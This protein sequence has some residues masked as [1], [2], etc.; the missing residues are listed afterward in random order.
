MKPQVNVCLTVVVGIF[1]FAQAAPGQ[2]IAANQPGTRS[3][4]GG[5]STGAIAV[6][7]A[8][9]GAPY[10][11][12]CDG[13]AVASELGSGGG[14]VHPVSLAS[15]DLDED[16]VPDLVS[17]YATGG[18]GT[19][20]V[21]RGNEAALW[22]YGA[23][24]RNGPLPAFL[25]Q[26]RSFSLPESPDFLVTGDFDADGHTDV[27][28]AHRGGGALYFLKGDGRG[29]FLKPKRV[30]VD[31]SITAMISG[32][33]N[34]PDG[35]ADIV[36][37][38]NT[39]NGTRVLVFES[40]RGAVQ[41]QP[42]IFRVNHPVT[43]L[44][45][46][47]F[48]G[49]AMNDLAV[50]AGDELM[51]IHARDRKLSMGAAERASVPRARITMQTEPF[52]IQAL[53]AGDFSGAGPSIAA[54]GN[55]G[56]IHI[57]EHALA[58]NNLLA[59]MLA[60]PAYTPAMQVPG[61]SRK[62]LPVTGAGHIAPSLAA[63]LE[64]LRHTLGAEGPE[65][66]EKN[67]VPLPS[68]FAQDAPRLVAARVSGSL[69]EDLVAPDSGNN[70]LHIFS[71]I[72]K[73]HRPGAIQSV[74]KMSLLASLD[75]EASPAA[76][77]PMRLS[78]SGLHGLVILQDGTT[79]PIVMQQTI[80]PGNI[81]T[82]TNTSD[83]II[84]AGTE[85]TGPAGSLRAAIYNA[86]NATGPAEVDFDIPTSD[87]GYNSATGTFL[88][89]PLSEAAPG[90][91]NDFALP[92]I[93]QTITI[94]GYTQPG[95]SP[96]TSSTT[97]N[98]KILIEI[99]GTMATTPGG[100]GLVPFDDTGSTY[101]GLDFTGWTNPD[102]ESGP[103]GETASG[104][105]GMEANGV[106]DYI[107][108]NFFGT[109]P[110]GTLAISAKTSSNYGNRIGIFA[111]NG[112]GFGNMEGGNII[113]GT[114]PQARNILSNNT[115]GGVLFLSTA[116]E[117]HLEGNFIGLDASGAKALGNIDDGAGS[118][119]ATITLGGTLPGDGNV[120]SSN[121]TDIDFND[122]TN[123]GQASDSIAQGNLIGTDAT[124]T[125]SV[126]LGNGVG[127][128]ILSGPTDETFGGTT[129]AARNVISGNLYGVYIFNY[130][131]GNIVQGNFIGTDVTGTKAIGNALQGF[132][133]GATD[134]TQVPA[135]YTA[136]GGSVA[137]AGNVIS[138]NTLDGVSISGTA[139]GGPY[140]TNQGSTILG[141]YIGTDV[142]G[143]KALGNGATGISL[144]TAA[145]SNVIGGTEPGSGNIIAFNKSHGILIDSASSGA[146]NGNNT[147]GNTILSNGG[148]G[149]RINSGADN[150]ISQN[151]IYQNAALGIDL[152]TAGPNA[153]TS[154]NS[155]NTG[156]NNSQ[157]APVLTAGTGTA[158]FTATATDP[159]GN[160]S[161]F[162]N[163]VAST[164]GNVFDLL[165][166]FNSTPST[167]YTIEF[168]SSPTGDPSGFGQ[169]LTYLGSTQ[170]TTGA[171]CSIAVNTPL[172]PDDADMSITLSNPVAGL[173][174]GPDFGEQVY[175]ASV[176]NLGASTA[177]NVVV[178]DVLPPSLEISSL[179]CN[180]GPCQFSVTTSLG[181]CTVNGQ[182]ITCDLG[183]MAPGQTAVVN[184]PVEAV[185][186]ETISNT[187][188]VSA[189]EADPVLA[190]NSSTVTTRSTYP[191]PEI[192]IE[193]A[194][195]NFVPNSAIAGSPNLPVTVYGTGFIPSSVVSFNGTNL[196][197][198]SFV[199]NQICGN[200]F[201][202]Y[203][204]AA[205]EVVV[206]A[207]MLT[208]VGTPNITVTNP[209]PGPGGAANVASVG[210]FNIYSACS[211]TI[212][213]SPDFADG[214]ENDGTTLI[215]E[216]VSVAANAASCSWTASS[217]V[218]WVVPL[219]TTPM[220]GEYSSLDFAVAPNSSAATRSGTITV[221]GQTVSFTQAASSSCD[222]TLGA[223]SGNFTPAGGAGSV[224]VTIIGSG[225]AP[226]V[227]SYASWITVPEASG[228]LLASGPATFT[229]AANTG[230]ART[231]TIMIG[232]YVFTVNQSAPSC[233]Y[234][235]SPATALWGAAGGTGA[236]G[237]TASSSSCAWTA[238]SSN[239]SVAT[240]TSGGS[241]TGN[242]TVNYSVAANKNGPQTPT[243]TV[244]DTN[245][246]SSAF[247]ISQASAYV[248]TFTIS[249]T[250]VSVP[251]DGTSNFF[252]LTASNNFC[253]WTATS[254]DPSALSI[255]L[256]SSGTGNGAVYY[257]VAQNTSG[258]R[259]ITIVAGCQ[260]FTVNQDGTA[261]SNPLPAITT[262]QPSGATAG[263]GAFTLTVNGS[264]FINGSV[265][266][267]NGNPRTTTYVSANQ[268]TAAILATDVATAGKP[269]VTVINP[270]PGGGT[271]NVVDFNITAALITPT[272]TVSP[273]PASITT[274]QSLTVTI[275]VAGGSG[276]PTPTGSVTLTSGSYTSAATT[277]SSG[278]T[279]INIPAGSLATGTDTLT[280]SYTPDSSSSSTYNSAT[281]SNTV[282]VTTPAKVTPTVAVSP[283]PSSI[284]T[285]QGLTVTVTVGGGSG[286]PTPTGSVTLSGGGYTS[287]VTTLTG[288][289]A[290]FTIA[291]GALAT[292][293]DTLTAS[294]TPDSSSSSTYNS[295]TGSNTVAVTTAAK[296]T[297]S[298]T[299]SPSPASITTKQPLTVTITVAGGTGNP[300]PTGSVVLTSGTYTSATTALSGGAATITIAAGTL[301]KGTD[302]LNV[303]Y[304]PDTA[305]STTY[306]SATGSNTVMVTT[307]GP[308]TPTVTV[309][310]S[311]A[312]ITT[313]QALTVNVAVSGGTGNPTPTGSVVL[314]SGTYTSAATTLSGGAAAI[315]ISA[316]TLPV[317]TDTLTVAYTPDTTSSTT[318]NPATGSNTVVVAAVVQVTVGTNPTS[319][320]FT[321][322]GTTYTSS[323]SLTWTVGTSHTIATTSPQTSGSTQYAFT[324]WSDGGALS[325]TVTAPATATT[326][327]AAFSTS[328]QLTTAA[329][330]SA[331]GTVTP[332]SG[333]FYAA[334]TV[335]NLS[336]TANTGFL[337]SSWTGNVASAS[338]ATT[339]VTMNAAQS[340][341]ANFA[342]APAP[343]ALLAP[344]S[345][346]FSAVAG[347]TSAAQMATISNTGN[348]ALTNI[349]ISITG[350]NASNFAQSAT[351]CGTTLAAGDACTISITFAPGAAGS[352]SAT[353]SVTDNAAGSPQT[354][355]LSGTGTPAPSFTVTS[356]TGSQTVQ[357]G[358]VAQYSITIAA[359]N[360]T[361]SNPVA[362]SAS[363][364][365]PGATAT[366]SQATVTPGSSS[367][368]SQLSIQTAGATAAAAGFMSSRW[369]LAGA[370]PLFGLLAVGRQ[371]R[372]RWM[373]FAVLLFASLGAVTAI[374]GCGGGFG[375]RSA[376]SY[377]ITVTGTSGAEQQTA[378]VQL[379]VQ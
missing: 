340:V 68:G 92:P 156:A 48:D 372:R 123:G 275:T 299:V 242:G 216:N 208:A 105:E 149:V 301:P 277:L 10:L 177:H 237:V 3:C 342:P 245:G 192:D 217:S 120:I 306:N 26:A 113:G 23:A 32:E 367:A 220:S 140:D 226:F 79:A 230:A 93:N 370:I 164:S 289:T 291:A 325:H 77:L 355:T 179:Y 231:G 205:I 170:V 174:I 333:T 157:N 33:I 300:T 151:S 187:A 318:Y 127:A 189:T 261:V 269:P 49:G 138:G 144:L 368:T 2:R 53:V 89:Q 90:A 246:G 339:T 305:S 349:A 14:A 309:T 111:D 346:S 359:Q 84:T 222:Y 51:V 178:T 132:Y 225:C 258:P 70:A 154:C 142:T 166:N 74:A 362:L 167:A 159:N 182:T 25:P 263:S 376:T 158:F 295:A 150:L 250:P 203:Y 37:G 215:A 130:T 328:Y 181:S 202:P 284:T 379:T 212:T 227:E 165:G 221:A 6:H 116:L 8:L 112:P 234:T 218:D 100:A 109:D 214:L 155:T 310:P 338:S 315:N 365:P 200:S 194:L 60:D 377:T 44:A 283:S 239:T 236:F 238:T 76:V 64:T 169:G 316:G 378:T 256:N 57:L 104:A 72:S 87:P 290:T 184:I 110:T 374:T 175:T 307:P 97:D 240:V 145:S 329:S 176:V 5:S 247:A 253:Q 330:P 66:M 327:T 228:L 36:I 292:G 125:L 251:A 19:I 323:Q 12:L 322:D 18:G 278:S 172:N 173:Q 190:N 94:D 297:P 286:N 62:G 136:L 83:A 115:A 50:G 279:T 183:T 96:N 99:D 298:V 241:G 38:V 40:P 188:T 63:R 257:S 108:G 17:G 204:C 133:Q 80:P 98:A 1:A 65:W 135:I 85:V 354:T 9:R 103:S 211:F 146:G 313:A 358:A 16:G 232:G 352:F 54:L 69:E 56:Q 302:T 235:L 304:T 244:A 118:N 276:N 139:P 22:P 287:A 274:K 353:L 39:A 106:G 308:I 296:V 195:P 243:I 348:A 266:N 206:P 364:L 293:T 46:G 255:T 270:T 71:T 28:A 119:G 268:V 117:A 357:P 126:S 11:N 356:T 45:L 321:V 163:A 95:A 101:R 282:A 67:V 191:E 134:S 288:G 347:V 363:G 13:R 344:S 107:E 335:V 61:A 294:Y 4:T 24:L 303:A 375:L 224:N 15:A 199:D 147:I 233:S 265:V 129:P 219:E 42:E 201:S 143:T 31:G 341:T 343:I 29:G 369:A 350:S 311:P 124:G 88:I 317:G 260:T 75:A 128:S 345:L 254:S 331:D 197:T 121:G 59:R 198:V 252:S 81:F 248:C 312:S 180:V 30:A 326:Y 210:S 267:F 114:T 27:V 360:G 264:G 280:A 7:A 229:V 196:P 52:T 193:G 271:S 373:I 141:N 259:T 78:K 160:T 34:R 213:P 249:P 43:A 161:E 337:F 281:G 20:T 186:S 324:S 162:S 285:K 58:G 168:F 223:P 320:S 185:T 314:T 262:L 148:A 371:R 207:S 122:L 171:D 272:V 21:Q 153:N 319:L 366:F 209:D 73:A 137:G 41:D 55:D 47:H 336:A 351:T 91:F 102:I 334:G 82:V 361:F 131:T 86:N 152:G 332:A 273:S 35:L